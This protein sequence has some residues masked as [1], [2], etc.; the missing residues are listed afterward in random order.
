M[1]KN[2][3]LTGASGFIGNNIYHRIDKKKYNLYCVDRNK[4]SSFENS[5]YLNLTN[6]I[7][8][9]KKLKFECI[10][11]CASL[12]SSNFTQESEFI[13]YYKNNIIATKNLIDYANQNKV[14][15][16]IF[17][18]SVSIYGEIKTN[19]LKINSAIINPNKYGLSKLVC[20]KLLQDEDN[21]FKSISIRL[22]G[23]I[24]Q[25]SKRNLLSLLLKKIKLS[26]NIKIYNPYELFNNCLDSDELV[27]FIFLLLDKDLKIHDIILLSAS[28]PIKFLLVVNK[29]ITSFKSNSKIKII[30]NKKNSFVIENT[31]ANHKYKYKPISTLET[32]NK[33]IKKNT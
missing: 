27:K 16:F 31:Y 10:I 26:Q 29:L 1:K 9:N 24:G 25:L 21:Y 2:I 22:P 14:K 32:I 23:V 15:K 19:K 5:L 6:K 4:K 13:E 18:S 28:R 12:S 3:L 11:H 20:E 8:I 30:K 33:F 7:K 17:L